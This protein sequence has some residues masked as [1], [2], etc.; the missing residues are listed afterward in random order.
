MTLHGS[1]ETTEGGLS[2][3]SWREVRRGVSVPAGSEGTRSS[4]P[5]NLGYFGLLGIV[6]RLDRG[7]KSLAEASRA[8]NSRHVPNLRLAPFWAGLGWAGPRTSSEREI[9]G[10]QAADKLRAGDRNAAFPP[11]SFPPALP[12]VGG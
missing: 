7:S 3:L 11:G 4:K 9:A 1:Y 12:Y 8:L 6:N 2:V 5:R 10:W